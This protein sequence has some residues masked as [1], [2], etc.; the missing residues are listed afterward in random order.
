[1]VSANPQGVITGFSFAPASTPI[2]EASLAACGGFGGGRH[3]YGKRTVTAA[4][5]AMGLS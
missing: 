3:S 1:L 2:L 5:Q 4:L